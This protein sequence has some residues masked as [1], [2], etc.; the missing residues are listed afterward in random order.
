MPRVF[1]GVGHLDYAASLSDIMIEIAHRGRTTK[2]ALL[3]KFYRDVDEWRLDKIL[4]SLES[5]GNISTTWDGSTRVIVSKMDA[6]TCGKLFTKEEGGS[7]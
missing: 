1:T 6:E 4:S 5:A 7:E 3:A 2:R